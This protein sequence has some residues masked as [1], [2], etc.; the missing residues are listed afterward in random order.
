MTPNV[1]SRNMALA[2]RA[3]RVNGLMIVRHDSA[4][5]MLVILLFNIVLDELVF[6]EYT[7]PTNLMKR[8]AFINI[9]QTLQFDVQLC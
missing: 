4:D 7:S 6:V 1:I 2:A 5:T 9:R 3:L 8:K